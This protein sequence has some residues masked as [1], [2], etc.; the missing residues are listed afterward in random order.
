MISSAR[1]Q[2]A[3]DPDGGI[4]AERRGALLEDVVVQ[5]AEMRRNRYRLP[6]P[7]SSCI[8]GCIS[9]HRHA[10][11]GTV[12]HSSSGSGG[13]RLA[14]PHI[15]P[16][17]AVALDARIGAMLDL[18]R[19]T[20]SAAARSACRCNCRRDRISSRD[21]S[22]AARSRRSCRN[23]ARRRDASNARRAARPARR[24][25]RNA[26]RSSPRSR[27]RSGAP[28]GSGSSRDSKAATQ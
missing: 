5:D 24:C 21:T 14:R 28:S 27:T 15:G 7:A 23:T 10:I 3:N 17:D 4:T 1:R 22:S 13:M 9:R 2:I 6:C 25:A 26:I 16:D 18:V 8:R 20:A 12:S 19:R 11:S